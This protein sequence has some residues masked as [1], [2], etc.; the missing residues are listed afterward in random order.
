MSQKWSFWEKNDLSMKG[1][2][3]NEEKGKGEVRVQF[4]PEE[5]P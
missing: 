3:K 1:K 4:S 2:G 5:Q